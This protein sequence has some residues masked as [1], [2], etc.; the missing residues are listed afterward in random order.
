MILIDTPGLNDPNR[1]RT[2]KQIFMDLVNTLRHPLFSQE[3]GIT[4]FIQCIMQDNSERIRDSVLN[5]MLNLLLILSV[6]NSDTKLEDLKKHPSF[7]IVFNNVSK[8]KS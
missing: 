6:F 5:A 1:L 7:I 3:E 8:Y 2:D 4:S